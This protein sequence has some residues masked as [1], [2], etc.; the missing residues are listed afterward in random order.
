[1]LAHSAECLDFAACQLRQYEIDLGQ[2]CIAFKRMK[3]RRGLDED[4]RLAD[5]LFARG[6]IS[7]QGIAAAGADGFGFTHR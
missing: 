1:M 2:R 6:E 5:G 3:C 7:Q 4:E